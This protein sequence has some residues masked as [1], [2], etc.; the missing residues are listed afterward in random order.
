[1]KKRS[2]FWPLAMIATG[3]LWLLTGMGI[4]PS[5]NLWALTHILPFVLIALGVGMNHVMKTSTVGQRH[6]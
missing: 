1:M 3:V 5:A 4:V 2:I 6:P